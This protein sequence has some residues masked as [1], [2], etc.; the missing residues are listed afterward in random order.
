MTFPVLSL[1]R[2]RKNIFIFL[3]VIGA[4]TVVG[5]PPLRAR[6]ADVM[7]GRIPGNLTSAA[8]TFDPAALQKETAYSNGSGG[9]LRGGGD[10]PAAA[11]SAPGRSV[12]AAAQ[13]LKLDAVE[14]LG[15]PTDLPTGDD[16]NPASGLLAYH[17]ASGLGNASSLGRSSGLAGSGGGGGGGGLGG[18][19]P[20]VRSDFN[21]ESPAPQGVDNNRATTAPNASP[22]GVARRSARADVAVVFDPNAPFG[23]ADLT[24][25]GDGS[26]NAQ[27]SAID[28]NAA[29]LAAPEPGTLLLV[30]NGVAAAWGSR[31]LRRRR[32][33]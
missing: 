14:E 7:A 11:A 3:F 27:L 1:L 13:Q 17:G 10:V 31:V 32:N 6:F 8:P 12:A 30:A 24:K 22:T 28:A 19:S 18:F 4:A 5:N 33:R 25:A 16:S 26:E 20:G 29:P 2:R 23:A 15:A 21:H 9:R